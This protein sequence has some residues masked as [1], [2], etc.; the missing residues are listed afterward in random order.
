MSGDLDY[1][2]TIQIIDKYFSDWAP[3]ESLAKWTPVKEDPITAPKEVEV[4]GPDAEWVEL[5]FRFDGRTSAD[6]QLLRLT[7]V[8]LSSQA[9]PIELNL[10]QKQKT[11]EA[12]SGLEDMN[13]YCLHVLSGKPREGQ[14][15]DE[16][17]K[18]FISGRHLSWEEAGLNVIGGWCGIIIASAVVEAAHM[19]LKTAPK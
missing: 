13:D 11:L 17:K 8:I 1:D 3:N 4:Y 6:Y 7:N 16:V 18:L 9:G 19:R 10:T 2:K 5:A 12:S 14:S 15:L